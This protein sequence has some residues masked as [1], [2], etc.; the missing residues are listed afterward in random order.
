MLLLFVLYL[1]VVVCGSQLTLER[2]L[3]AEKMEC[4]SARNEVFQLIAGAAN[5][6][7]EEVDRFRVDSGEFSYEGG[8]IV[9]SS[10]KQKWL[11]SRLGVGLGKLIQ[12]YSEA[13][14]LS[15]SISDCWYDGDWMSQLSSLLEGAMD[16]NKNWGIINWHGSVFGVYGE[17][18]EEGAFAWQKDLTFGNVF[19][20]HLDDQVQKIFHVLSYQQEEQLSKGMTIDQTVSLSRFNIVGVTHHSHDSGVFAHL[21][22]KKRSLFGSWVLDK[23]LARAVIREV[24]WNATI[25]DFGAGGGHYSTWFN[26][27]GVVRSSHAYD[28]IP[29][30]YKITKGAVQEWNLADES[31]PINK[32]FDWVFCIEVAE[33]IPKQFQDAMIRNWARYAKI[34]FIISWS[35]MNLGI[36]HVN[37]LPFDQVVQVIESITPFKL[38]QQATMRL[39][40]ASTKDYIARTVALFK[41]IEANDNHIFDV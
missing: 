6:A 33:H 10:N 21:E 19:A 11:V 34:G 26:E 7:K 39:R 9:L 27:T 3:I 40:A 13:V 38:H 24:G 36:G 41:R 12:G 37:P 18:L 29:D 16:M 31:K 30:I 15:T 14:A 1:G 22:A 32:I 35:D 23:G 2:F 20:D 28:G 5:E 4:I 25:G 8:S 17:V